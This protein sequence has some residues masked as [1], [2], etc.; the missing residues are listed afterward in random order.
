MR[1]GRHPGRRRAGLLRETDLDADANQPAEAIRAALGLVA[2]QLTPDAREWF[3]AGIVR[4]GMADGPLIEQ[5]RQTMQAVASDLGMSP[6]QAI[7]V[8]T[9]IE[10]G[11]PRR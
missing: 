6:A 2:G 3:L 9:M 7:G 1:V 10:Q 8:M 11:A 5:E 4:V